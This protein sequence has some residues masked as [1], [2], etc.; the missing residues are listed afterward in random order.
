MPKEEHLSR[1]NSARTLRSADRA[2]TAAVGAVAGI[3]L[4]RNFFFTERKIAEPV[5]PDFAVG[6]AEFT[7]TV[8][9]L[10]GPPIVQRNLVTPLRNGC[11][12]FP[13]MLQAIREATRSITFENFV[14][15]EGRLA[16]EFAKTFVERA[17]A[18]V[19]V[20]FLQ[21]ALGCAELYG[22]SMRMLR[23]SPVELE[24]F[25]LYGLT[26]INQRTHR[27]LLVID[28]RVGFIGGAA[29]SDDWE[30]NADRPN[31]WREMQYCV[32]GP[33][34]SQMQQ[35]FLENWMETRGCVLLGDNYFP[36]LKPAGDQMCQVF[37]SS[38]TEGA[39]SARLMLLLSLA[40]AQKSIRIANAYFLPDNMVIDTIV[41]ARRRG[42]D[43]EV[44]VPG[45][46]TDQMLVREVGRNR[47]KSMIRAGVR[48]FEFQPSCFHCKYMIVDDCWSTVG[49]AN[50]D[51]RSL[52]LNEEANLNVLDASFARQHV[53]IFEDDK[54]ASREITLAEWENRPV[55]EKIRGT[56]GS[57]LRSQL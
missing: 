40:A 15:N 48:F 3:L 13:A 11:E 9:Q 42:V 30:G 36:E 33:V 5:E 57:V 24:I 37:K 43:V 25:R 21:D 10:F 29:I 44:I 56:A 55:R 26:R 47:W 46:H 49:S 12:I 18:G 8:S 20:H 6:D 14:W 23:N 31:L 41:K 2:I 16:M 19:R 54:A 4:S 53:Q 39:D 27:K 17:K 35:A 50:L 7:R 28:G 45:E 38:A 52:R 51:D 34:V 32:E 1:G 22:P